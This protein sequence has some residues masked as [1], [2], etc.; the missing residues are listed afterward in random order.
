VAR[1]RTNE[2]ELA[3]A[4]IGW[5]VTAGVRFSRVAGMR[6]TAGNPKLRAWLADQRISYVLAV[7]CDE[8]ITIA[9]G[10]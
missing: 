7:A 10:P 2:P 4:M 1:Q 3:K 8:M 6:S 5:A 9:A